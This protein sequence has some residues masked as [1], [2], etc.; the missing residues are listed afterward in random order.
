MSHLAAPSLC[1]LR[2]L[3]HASAPHASAIQ[4]HL[5]VAPFL[6]SV[7]P[8]ACRRSPLSRPCRCQATRSHMRVHCLTPGR[9]PLLSAGAK[10]PCTLRHSPAH[11][12]KMLMD[13]LS[14]LFA[15]DSLLCS[16]SMPAP[17]SSSVDS[18]CPLPS[19]GGRHPSPDLH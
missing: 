3:A 19:V 11:R 8:A 10:P 17:S 7:P 4:D 2:V 12:L 1:P 15:C 5:L 6:G 14:P 18:I 9:T 13:P 16:K